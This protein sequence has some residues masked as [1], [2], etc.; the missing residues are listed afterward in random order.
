MEKGKR[1]PVSQIEIARIA[2][3]SRTTV[4]FV[5]NNVR[6]KNISEETRQRVVATAREFGYTP[7]ESAVDTATSREGTMSLFVCHSES[8]FSD[9]YIMRLL[10][11]MGPVLHKSRYDLRVVQFRVSRHDYV[12]TARKNGYEGVLLL[13]THAD[14]PGIAAFKESG[15]PFV[16]IGSLPDAEL[17]QV[18]I[19][20]AEAAGRVGK[21]V[22]SLGHRDVAVVAHAPET[23]LAVKA[24]LGGFVAALRESGV[25]VPPSRISYAHFTEESGHE[26]MRGI[27]L[28]GGP[29]TAV[30]ATNDMVAYGAMRALD[31]AGLSVPGDVSVVGFDDDYMSRYTNPP[32]TTMTLPAEGIGRMAA[33][34]LLDLMRGG[35]AQRG[36]QLLPT[37]LTIRRSCAE[38]AAR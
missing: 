4:S 36:V 16:V 10:E 26:A 6:G 20:N 30:F 7:D 18:D 19:D 9:A 5:L 27:L 14:D 17:A 23:F 33:E 22:A 38:A 31:D 24:R 35:R 13:N 2:G 29:P 28:R 11:G 8:V 1:K 12:E 37:S 15:M 32:L 21:Y 25:D 3:V 34:T